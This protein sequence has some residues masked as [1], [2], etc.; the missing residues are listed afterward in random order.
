MPLD[1]LLQT[2]IPTGCGVGA[3]VVV[4]ALILLPS[5]AFASP[6][7]PVWIPGIYDGADGDD[8]ITLVTET[9][10][11]EDGVACQLLFPTLS[12]EGVMVREL[13]NYA[14][15][16]GLPP[17]RSPPQGYRRTVEFVT[18]RLASS[19]PFTLSVFRSSHILSTSFLTCL[20]WS[21][22]SAN[23]AARGPSGVNDLSQREDCS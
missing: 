11:S 20:V 16:H 15:S 22:T 21:T 18:P 4:T 10:A 12:S 17:A 6:P 9:V 8:I 14:T 5:V 7:D 13:E 1:R 3:W 2:V 23:A 19:S